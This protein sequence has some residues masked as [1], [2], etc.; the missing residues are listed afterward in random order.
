MINDEEFFSKSADDLAMALVGKTL[1]HK[2]ENTWLSATI[3][4]TEAYYLAEKGSH[5]SLG[6]TPSREPMFAAPGT[7]YMY[8]ARGGD[9]LNFSAM[10]AGN[11]VLIKSA[12]VGQDT[13]HNTRAMHLMQNHLGQ[14]TRPPHRL[15]SGQ[16][17]LCKGLGLKVPD[18]WGKQFQPE[19]FYLQDIGNRPAQLV[20]TTRLGIPTGRDEHL[21]Q[22][23]IHPDHLK[24]C[25][26]NPL[27]MRN[28]PPPLKMVKNPS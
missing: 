2:V 28:N 15:L 12:I 5:S 24:S 9:S 6:R 8:Y 11:A 4:E 19:R 23:Y 25:T 10:G 14:H 21:M 20:Q 17:L 16:T 26:K 3:I 13:Q 7:I 27:T 18:W 22:R 1:F